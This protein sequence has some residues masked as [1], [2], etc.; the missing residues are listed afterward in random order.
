MR[1]T[2]IISEDLNENAKR[3]AWQKFSGLFMGMSR[4]D[5]V[6]KLAKQWADD[7]ENAVSRGVPARLSSPSKIIPEKFRGD[8]TILSDARNLANRMVAQKVGGSMLKGWN[9][10]SPWITSLGLGYSFYNLV[11]G[12]YEDA[13]KYQ[14][15]DFQAAAQVRIDRFVAEAVTIITVP[16]A[17]KILKLPTGFQSWFG[18]IPG[19]T[20]VTNA[21]AA[22]SPTA[23]IALQGWLATDEG[24]KAV[25]EFLVYN[26]FAN[27][28]LQPV[29]AWIGGWVKQKTQPLIDKIQ[30]F[31]DPAG[32]E[33]RQP[34]RDQRAAAQAQRD[35]DAEI[36][37]DPKTDP[38]NK[39]TPV[40]PR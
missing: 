35:A 8:S 23:N 15:A 30:D 14:G 6:E 5:L 24:R 9:Q 12:I 38:L 16:I 31:K 1:V 34:E 17:T 36:K 25:A 29:R 20:A 22:L 2:E 40:N 10:L 19:V 33:G 26:S 37:W 32:A 4:K 3:K 28:F 7:I 18:W 39:P 21:L 13:G 11:T 27:S